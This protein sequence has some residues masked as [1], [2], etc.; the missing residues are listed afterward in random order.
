MPLMSSQVRT[1]APEKYRV[2]PSS[3]SCEPGASVDI[4]VSLHGGTALKLC[5]LLL[6]QKILPNL[7]PQNNQMVRSL[8]FPTSHFCCTWHTYFRSDKRIVFPKTNRQTVDSTVRVKTFCSLQSVEMSAAGHDVPH[9]TQRNQHYLFQGFFLSPL[10]FML[11][12]V[13]FPL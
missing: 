1:T 9:R 11:W 13:F 4:V 10:A 12:W 3:S 6:S 2:K 7:E 8:T 5:T